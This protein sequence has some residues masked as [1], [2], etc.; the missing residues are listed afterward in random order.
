MPLWPTPSTRRKWWHPGLIACRCHELHDASGQNGEAAVNSL[1]FGLP[2]ARKG[3][4]FLQRRVMIYVV[5]SAG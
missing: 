3:W 4:G 2:H 5:A 1:P